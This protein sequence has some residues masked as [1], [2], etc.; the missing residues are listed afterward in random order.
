MDISA[1]LSHAEICKAIGTRARQRRKHLKLS[2]KELSEKSGVSVPTIGRFETGGVAT[3]GV[4]VKLARTLGS[5][6]TL[7]RMFGVPKYKSLNEFLAH[8]AE[9]TN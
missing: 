3:L 7:E 9:E 1:L 5:V 2:R 8:E 6:D 4:I